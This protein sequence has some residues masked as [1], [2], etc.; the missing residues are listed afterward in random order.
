MLIDIA[1]WPANNN[2]I[3]C[4][5][6]IEMMLTTYLSYKRLAVLGNNIFRLCGCMNC[7]SEL[8]WEA[9]SKSSTPFWM[10]MVISATHTLNKSHLENRT[11]TDK[12][13]QCIAMSDVFS[14]LISFSWLIWHLHEHEQWAAW[15]RYVE[16]TLITLYHMISLFVEDGNGK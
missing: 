12:L 5:S 6:V 4:C 7:F 16:T 9:A 3:Q 11:C 13:K 15:E 10:I 2:L 14:I 1:I 8:V